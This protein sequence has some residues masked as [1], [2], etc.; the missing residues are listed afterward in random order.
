[1]ATLFPRKGK[2]ISSSAVIANEDHLVKRLNLLEAILSI[3]MLFHRYLIFL[4]HNLEVSCKYKLKT[5]ANKQKVPKN[6]L[7][8]A[9]M[10][11][12]ST[13]HKI[14]FIPKHFRPLK[15]ALD[16]LPSVRSDKKPC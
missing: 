16:L 7:V 2:K 9:Q 3:V 4:Q 14:K 10:S 15:K 6:G 1:M 11:F 5:R 13:K 12:L 8:V